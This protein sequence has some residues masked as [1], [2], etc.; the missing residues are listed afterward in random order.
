MEVCCGQRSA[1]AAGADAFAG[2]SFDGAKR[3]DL[4]ASRMGTKEIEVASALGA[5]AEIVPNAQ[6]AR[7]A[8]IDQHV[9]DK[10]GRRLGGKVVVEPLDDHAVNAACA[11]HFELVTQVRD[12]RGRS[13]WV[14]GARRKELSWMRLECHDRGG[15]LQTSSGAHDLA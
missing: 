15:K 6:P 3:D 4:N 8:S 11:Q 5:K 10:L 12:A 9:V 13:I 2:R 1:Y 7:V 14:V